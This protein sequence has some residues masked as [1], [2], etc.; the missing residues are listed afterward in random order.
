MATELITIGA[1]VDRGHSITCSE[2]VEQ[3]KSVA[4]DNANALI[5]TH[6][7]IKEVKHD[8]ATAEELLQN[9]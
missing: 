1:Q 4:H 8:K 7:D 2:Q 6:G 9:G 5:Q 3:R